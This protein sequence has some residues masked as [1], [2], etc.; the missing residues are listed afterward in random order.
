M[1]LQGQID[2]LEEKL[3]IESQSREH[4][5]KEKMDELN[6]KDIQI[7]AL[8]EKLDKLED[9]R[10]VYI[11]KARLADEQSDQMESM[12]TRVKFLEKQLSAKDQKIR[13]LDTNPE[14]FMQ[15]QKYVHEEL[16]RYVER[17]MRS[18]EDCKK[19]Q[20]EAYHIITGP[21]FHVFFFP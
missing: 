13:A 17:I 6:L 5:L 1:Q 11:D 12:R 4:E 14:K 9:E 8:Q 16:T 7:R 3:R 20:K 15:L 21:S 18:L 2:L 10:E 19:S